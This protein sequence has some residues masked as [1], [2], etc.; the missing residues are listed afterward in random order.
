MWAALL[1]R[2]LLFPP[3]VRLSPAPLLS[4]LCPPKSRAGAGDLGPLQQSCIP[5]VP[6]SFK[7]SHFAHV[8]HNWVLSRSSQQSS[9]LLH[10]NIR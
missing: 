4:T 1:P 2:L 9:I 7:P 6:S 5:Q 8:A 3:M 10:V